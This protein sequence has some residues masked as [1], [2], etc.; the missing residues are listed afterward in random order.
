ML[1]GISHQQFT[2]FGSWAGYSNKSTDYM[3]LGIYQ[4]KNR[5]TLS[6]W[7]IDRYQVGEG[8][9]WQELQT[10]DYWRNLQVRVP[11]AGQ[12]NFEAP[13]ALT[14]SHNAHRLATFYR[15]IADLPPTPPAPAH[16]KPYEALRSLR[17]GP[18]SHP[19][20]EIAQFSPAPTS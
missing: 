13:P 12:H 1:R 17:N 14:I 15:R 11:I 5:G 3:E 19:N 8:V 18:E 2:K 16:A 9:G 4:L 20:M 7:I 6:A 10:D